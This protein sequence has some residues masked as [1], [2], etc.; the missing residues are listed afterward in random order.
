MVT[1]ACST[2]SG[3]RRMNTASR[4]ISRVASAPL[5]R[6][7]YEQILPH[8]PVTS[9]DYYGCVDGEAGALWVF[10]ADV[11]PEHFS[12]VDAGLRKAA[13]DW[14]GV[15]HT[16]ASDL[17]AAAALPDR[18]PGYYLDRLRSARH[19]ITESKSNPAITTASIAVLDSVLMVLDTI[20]ADWAAV[21]EF[22]ASMPRT[23][24][25]GDLQP[26]N[27]FVRRDGSGPRLYPI[28]WEMA[29]W[30]I[31]AP[32]VAPARGPGVRPDID[33]ATYL[34]AVKP[35]WRAVDRRVLRDWVVVGLLFRRLIAVDW[36]APSLRYEWPERSVDQLSVYRPQLEAAFARAPWAP[37]ASS[38]S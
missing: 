25:H 1:N 38:G 11:G 23:L 16:R 3:S 18:G 30:G 24:T 6:V 35:R 31:P 22:C 28:D 33:L 34:K 36:A 7:I 26:K 21:E 29:G 13:A 15:L 27:L 20:E 5:E 9:P 12:R 8:V 37:R 4:G 19:T 14:L 2:N 17:P 10:L 32:D